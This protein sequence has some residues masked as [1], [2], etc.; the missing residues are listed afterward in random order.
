MRLAGEQKHFAKGPKD[1]SF[2]E[3]KTR[4]LTPIVWAWEGGG[5]NRWRGTK[6]YQSSGA[7]SQRQE[8]SQTQRVIA[9]ARR[10]LRGTKGERLIIK[11]KKQKKKK[12]KEKDKK[13][14]ER[15]RHRP[16]MRKKKQPG[17]VRR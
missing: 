3:K 15:K 7:N 1:G 9:R 10:V 5:R 13:G 11:K 4:K 16:K 6:G 12:K 17:T 2:I 8:P 14:H